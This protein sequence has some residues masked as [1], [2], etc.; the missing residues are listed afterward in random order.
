MGIERQYKIH[1]FEHFA[2]F[3]KIYHLQYY[4][5]QPRYKFKTVIYYNHLCVFMATHNPT[6]KQR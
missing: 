4:L 3:R 6:K 1:E 2:I 5:E